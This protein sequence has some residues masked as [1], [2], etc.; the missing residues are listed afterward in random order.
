MKYATEMASDAMIYITCFIRLV[1]ELRTGKG[2]HTDADLIS[3]F[4]FEA[5]KAE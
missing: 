1:Q 2:I 5:R 3:L 4:F